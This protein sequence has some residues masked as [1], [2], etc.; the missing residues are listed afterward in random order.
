M[1]GG[2]VSEPRPLH[3]HEGCCEA[4]LRLNVRG[5]Q[6]VE[7]SAGALRAYALGLLSEPAPDRPGDL[8]ERM[9]PLAAALSCVVHGDGDAGTVAYM[10]RRLSAAERD[11]LLVVAV[12][13]IP[14]EMP[15]RTALG[16][17]DFDE[18]GRGLET[19]PD[20]RG[21]VRNLGQRVLDRTHVPMARGPVDESRSSRDWAELKCRAQELRDAGRSITE[22][23]RELEVSDKSVRR[24]TEAV[25]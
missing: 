14:P 23:C 2:A 6:A 16:W 8:A 11:A 22:I 25:A 12:G 17:V 5:V 3:P 24:W 19:R 9:V 13:M 15:I 18:E 20:M 10:L 4:C 21:T 7:E 1:N